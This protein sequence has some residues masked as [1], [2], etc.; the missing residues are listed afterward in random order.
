ML[1]SVWAHQVTQ[2]CLVCLS[3]NTRH[4]S[5]TYSRN[6]Q[7]EFEDNISWKTSSVSNIIYKYS[8]HKIFQHK[9]VCYYTNHHKSWFLKWFTLIWNVTHSFINW[10]LEFKQRNY[11]YL[12][13]PFSIPEKFPGHRVN[14]NV[15]QWCFRPVTQIPGIADLLLCTHISCISGEKKY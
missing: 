10:F 6:T 1:D 2:G 3:S 12:K 8:I 5:P 15:G 14:W 7:Y 9:V 4:T 13:L 11:I